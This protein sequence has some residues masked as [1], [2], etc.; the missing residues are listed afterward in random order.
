ML[1]LFSARW[2]EMPRLPLEGHPPRFKRSDFRHFYCI[3]LTWCTSLKSTYLTSLLADGT[4][5]VI[6]LPIA[7]PK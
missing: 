1:A 7:E 6:V 4:W 2:C 5:D 3:S